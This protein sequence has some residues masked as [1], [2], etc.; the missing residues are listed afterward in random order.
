M[1]GAARACPSHPSED[2]PNTTT[3][4]AALA[5]IGGGDRRC[6]LFERREETQGRLSGRFVTV[7]LHVNDGRR[8]QDASID[9][10]NPQT[11]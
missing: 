7:L 8:H 1:D 10:I 5:V 2:R 6:P 11:K 9:V 4:G 3:S